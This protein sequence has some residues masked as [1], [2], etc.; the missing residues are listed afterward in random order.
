MTVTKKIL[1]DDIYYDH[2]IPTFIF[3]L[4]G[5][6]AGG[7]NRA[8]N[9]IVSFAPENIAGATAGE[10]V[11]QSVT[12]TDIPAG[13]YTAFESTVSRYDFNHVEDVSANGQIV[14][15]TV[16]FDLMNYDDGHA[17][18]VNDKKEWQDYSDSSSITNM[19]K[20]SR[21]LVGL[22]V[23][24]DGPAV[25][26]AGTELTQ[27]LTVTALY[28]DGNATVLTTDNYTISATIAPYQSGDYT[29]TV[30]YTESGVTKKGNFTFSINYNDSMHPEIVSM[31]LESKSG[32]RPVYD[33]GGAITQDEYICKVKYNTGDIKILTRDEYS[34]NYTLAPSKSGL[35]NL[36]ASYTEYGTVYNSNTVKFKVKQR[37]LN[38]YSWEKIQQI[39]ASGKGEEV[40]AEC[41]ENGC[42][43][44]IHLSAATTKSD[45][46][47]GYY[48]SG[49]RRAI[50]KQDIAVNI[51]E[52]NHDT[53]TDGGTG[54][55]ATFGM[56]VAE[57]VTVNGELNYVANKEDYISNV[58]NGGLMNE[59]VSMES[60]RNNYSGATVMHMFLDT[61][62]A[63]C[64]PEDLRN[65]I[66]PVDKKT[67]AGNR[68]STINIRSEKLFLFTEVELLGHYYKES[69]GTITKQGRNRGISSTQY[70]Y[71]GSVAG[72]G[73]Q[74]GYYS[75]VN[76]PANTTLL[77]N[78]LI[79]K[80]TWWEAS[81]DPD[82]RDGFLRMAQDGY[83]GTYD[84]ATNEYGVSFGFTIR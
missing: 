70:G 37:H 71:L 27:Y 63:Q 34:L 30:G 9:K 11:S 15:E 72:E 31:T 20:A 25:L 1:Y 58:G 79:R 74:Y 52:F 23:V 29:V 7:V 59:R 46:S 33:P 83:A 43:K 8:W 4:R 62:Y 32:T 24:Y 3:T 76:D 49:V 10:Y 82:Y 38:D 65:I 17:T 12:F 6:D 5:V 50:A 73:Y 64:L 28:D 44:V 35:Y 84:Y 41:Y 67:S 66:V 75:D 51:L 42:C 48:G 68:S 18:F 2:G 16:E 19:I 14:H 61:V 40:F 78:R 26:D 80:A 57:K 60:T 81:P 13:T 53:P 36:Q 54:P 22:K 39:V 56:A 45:Y 69:N 21:K 55:N 47:Y 77:K